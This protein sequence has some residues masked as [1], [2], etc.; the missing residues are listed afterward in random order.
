MNCPNCGAPMRPVPGRDYFVCDYCTTFGFP[1]ESDE[2]VRVMGEWS[3]HLCPICRLGLVSAK[4]DG[5]PVFHCRKCRGNLAEPP[6]FRHI[7]DGRRAKV[8]KVQKMRPLDSE[9]LKRT[10]PCPRCH[11][12]MDVHPYYGPG[13]AI[14]DTCGNCALIWLDHGELQ[15]IVTAP[16]RGRG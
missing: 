8:P 13:N 14:I 10:V 5:V 4:I 6:A 11:N 12:P 9:Q 2:G 7:V 3:H 1:P 16:E 15:V